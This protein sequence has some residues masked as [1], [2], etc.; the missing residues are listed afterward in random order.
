MPEGRPDDGVVERRH[1]LEHV[2]LRGDQAHHVDGAP[3]QARRR[4]GAVSARAARRLLNLD[5]RELQPQLRR[6]MDRLEEVLVAMDDFGGRFLQREQLVGAQVA[7][8][9][10]GAGARQDR[11]GSRFVGPCGWLPGNL[12]A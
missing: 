12:E 6:L 4:G 2:Q 9:V 8:V 3:D 5:A 10:R 7:L 1:V 11:F